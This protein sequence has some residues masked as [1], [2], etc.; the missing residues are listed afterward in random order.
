MF[1]PGQKTVAA[2]LVLPTGPED[3]N[4]HWVLLLPAPPPVTTAPGGQFAW[5]V[6]LVTV[7]DSVTM[8]IFGVGPAGPRRPRGPRL[9]FFLFFL[10]VRTLDRFRSSGVLTPDVEL[11]PAGVACP[12][13]ATAAAPR[14]ASERTASRRPGEGAGSASVENEGISGTTCPFGRKDKQVGGAFRIISPTVQD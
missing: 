11:A 2:Q 8:V 14:P 4:Q 9:P 6:W 3:T 10:A 13:R 5:T 1:S 12:N 7:A